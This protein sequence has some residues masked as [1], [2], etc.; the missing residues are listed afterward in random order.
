MEQLD[1]LTES[2]LQLWNLIITACTVNDKFEWLD[3]KCHCGMITNLLWFNHAMMIIPVPP[4]GVQSWDP[5]GMKLVNTT[6]YQ[7][8][9]V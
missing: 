6:S 1:F 2:D 3:F 8:S 5:V 9:Y 7:L 4:S